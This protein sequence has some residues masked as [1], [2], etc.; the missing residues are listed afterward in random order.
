[1]YKNLVNEQNP[2]N[3]NVVI[4]INILIQFLE[5]SECEQ[6]ELKFREN[7]KNFKNSI[8]ENNNLRN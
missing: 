2:V 6:D 1:M 5:K 7:I 3:S 4:F 8:D